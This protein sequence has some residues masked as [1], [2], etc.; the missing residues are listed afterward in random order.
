MEDSEY[1]VVGDRVL[2]LRDS[3]EEAGN[4]IIALTDEMKKPPLTGRILSK[5][6]EVKYH[7]IGDK[8]CFTEYAGYYLKT[9]SDLE[10]TDYIVMREDELIAIKVA[11]DETN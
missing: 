4:T 3:H 9:K 10:D 1:R 8:V 11:S 5:G 2:V 6:T 7:E